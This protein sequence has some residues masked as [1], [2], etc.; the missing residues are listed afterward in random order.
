MGSGLES[1]KYFFCFRSDIDIDQMQ[2]SQQDM[3]IL[4][5]MAIRYSKVQKY[6]RTDKLDSG[7]MKNMIA[8]RSNID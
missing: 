5:I 2:I 1:E 8:E 4:E 3:R 6:R 7:I